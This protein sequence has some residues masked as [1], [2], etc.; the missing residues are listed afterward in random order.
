M[1]SEDFAFMLEMRPGNIALIENG[2][3]AGLHD[4]SYD[5]N[6][7]AIPYGVAYWERLIE[8]AMPLVVSTL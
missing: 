5:F 7:A 4:P 8:K 3:T 2:S 1:G 6:D